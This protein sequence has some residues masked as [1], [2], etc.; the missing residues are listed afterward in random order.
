[1]CFYE[2]HIVIY[3]GL[4]INMES[5]FRQRIYLHTNLK[6]KNGYIVEYTKGV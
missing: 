5:F 2:T 3:T 4:T 6:T 1:M